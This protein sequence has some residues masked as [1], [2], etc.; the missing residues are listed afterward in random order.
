MVISKLLEKLYYKQSVKFITY[1]YQKG[2]YTEGRRAFNNEKQI[3]DLQLELKQQHN[4]L[5][6]EKVEKQKMIRI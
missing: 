3:I 6:A 2:S 5:T 4:V 1:Q